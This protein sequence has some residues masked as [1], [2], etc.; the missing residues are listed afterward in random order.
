M[1]DEPEQGQGNVRPAPRGRR[2]RIALPDQGPILQ[3]PVVVDADGNEHE[4]AL[5]LRIELRDHVVDEAELRTAQAPVAAE[6]AFGVDRLDDPRGGRR[7]DVAGEHLAVERIARIAAHEV[8][9]ERTDE[10]LQRPDPRP[11]P[12]RVAERGALGGE[13]G[14]DHVVHVAAV[15]HHEDDARVRLDLRERPLVGVPHADPVEELDGAPCQVVPDPEVEPRVERRNDLARVAFDLAGQDL[16]RRARLPG[17][18]LDRLHHPGVMGQQLD[19]DPAPGPME[20]GDPEVEP[21]VQLVDHALDPP[22]EE[23]AHARDEE[24]VE[25][26]PQHE[27]AARD[28]DPDWKGDRLRHRG[29]ALVHPARLATTRRTSPTPV[30]GESASAAEHR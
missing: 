1:R 11:L 29:S 28:R 27:R 22:P 3:H 24:P 10:R 6:P 17:P 16:A 12:D 26:R 19:E 23:P 30:A 20:S 25:N 18:A 8:R 7:L 21:R 9:P 2:L 13:V 14:H 15:V 4:V 5:A